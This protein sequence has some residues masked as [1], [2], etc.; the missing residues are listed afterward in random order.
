VK[1]RS[2]AILLVLLIALTLIGCQRQ[3]ATIPPLLELPT[4]TPTFTLTFTFT[5]SFTWTPT[6]T[7][8]FTPTPTVTP[9]FTPTNTPTLTNTPPATFTPTPTY[10][11][12]PTFT[13]TFTFTPSGP[14]ITSF[15][16]DNLTM[17]AGGTTV[18]RWQAQGDSAVLD[19]L[20]AQGNLTQSQPVPVTGELAVQIP[21]GLGALVTFRLT[22]IRQGI[23]TSQSLAITITCG[24]DWFFGNQYAQGYCPAD[25]GAVGDGLYQQFDGGLMIYANAASQNFPGNTV[26]VLFY[27]G[28]QWR[29]YLNTWDGV[30]QPGDAPPPGRY[31]PQGILGSVWQNGAYNNQH[32]RDFL[33]FAIAPQTGGTRTIQVEAGGNSVYIDTP[34]GQVYRLTGGTTGGTWSQVK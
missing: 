3:Q 15:T 13:P 23:P 24:R 28:N 17:P 27:A 8:T 7:P 21:S 6:F 16:A 19:R 4:I 9:T 5:P 22:V 30:S 18:L 29:A 10:T 1:K 32:V 2:L 12:T 11:F 20:D 25:V 33:Q 14:V 34:T 31:T 26:Y